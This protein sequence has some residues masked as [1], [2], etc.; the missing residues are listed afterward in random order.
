MKKIL[1]SLASLGTVV[2]PIAVAVS[3]GSNKVAKTTPQ[4]KTN[5]DSQSTGTSQHTDGTGNHDFTI[6]PT[7]TTIEEGAFKGAILPPEFKIPSTVTTIGAEAFEGATLP[8]GFI[9]P[10]SV[11]LIEGYAFYHANL[12]QGFRVP[13]TV[14]TTGHEAFSEEILQAWRTGQNT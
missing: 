13:S 7:A 14:T 2:A 12:P 4:A 5:V 11:T 10:P 1:L 3:C 8:K 6:P 9:I